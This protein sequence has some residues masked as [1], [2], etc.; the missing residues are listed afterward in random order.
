[1]EKK[2]FEEDPAEKALELTCRWLH[3]HKMALR[4][5]IAADGIYAGMSLCSPGGKTEFDDYDFPAWDW[6]GRS[7]RK[8][9]AALAVIQ[10]LFG[11]DGDECGNGPSAVVE[12]VS[13]D[14]SPGR[15]RTEIRKE[16]VPKFS[17]SSL[18][19]FVLKA[20]ASGDMCA[21]QFK[22]DAATGIKAMF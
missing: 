8:E 7:V 9:D 10:W 14:F 6:A 20:E 12:E 18:E 5:K 21:D 4:E 11:E 1:M 3:A 19:E 2:D 16:P 17:F 13:R 15:Y 22:Q